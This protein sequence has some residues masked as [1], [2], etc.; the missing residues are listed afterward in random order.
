L[1]DDPFGVGLGRLPR[2]FALVGTFAQ[3]IAEDAIRRG[4]GGGVDKRFD[5]FTK[6]ARGRVPVSGKQTN[7]V[8]EYWI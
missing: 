7:A 4:G 6:S 1:R 8:Q 2:D 3:A 5:I